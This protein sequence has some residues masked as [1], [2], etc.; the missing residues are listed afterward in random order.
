MIS[1]KAVTAGDNCILVACSE[2]RPH[3]WSEYQRGG[4]SVRYGWGELKRAA[5]TTLTPVPTD[6]V[7]VCPECGSAWKLDAPE[8]GGGRGDG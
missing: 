8:V 6:G 4:L 3:Q 7:T 1:H 5:G 2:R